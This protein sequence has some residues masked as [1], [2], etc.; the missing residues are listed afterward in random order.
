MQRNRQSLLTFAG[1]GLVVLGAWLIAQRLI[2]PLFRPLEALMHVID[3]VFW[4]IALIAIGAVLLTR[5]SSARTGTRLYRSRTDRMIGGVLG[6]FAQKHGMNPTMVRIVYVAL[7]LLTATTLGI[8]LYLVALLVV[9]EEPVSSAAP[10]AP[11]APVPAA[12]PI[13]CAAPPV[14][15]APEH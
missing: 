5:D 15:A 1:V 4:P 7:T 8:M 3:V 10:V 11:A 12:P 9:P 14:P 6:G 13:P 2:F